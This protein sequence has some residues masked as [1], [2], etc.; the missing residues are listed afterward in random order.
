MEGSW[1]GFASPRLRRTAAFSLLLVCALATT[2]E[3]AKLRISN[4]YSAL[5]RYRPGREHTDYIVLHTT[6]GNDAPSLARVRQGGLAHYIVMRDGRVHRVIKRQLVARHAGRSMW[7]GTEN[8]D[9]HSIGIE[10]VG[11]HNRPLRDQQITALAELIRQLQST[12]GISD[13]HVLTHSMV[14]YGKPNRWH[15]HPHRGRKRCGMQF[16]QPELRARLGLESRPL[17]DPDVVA[18]RLVEADPYLA[19]VLYAPEEQSEAV[20][21][22]EFT[23]P[24]NNVISGTRT[25][26]FIARDLYDAPSTVYVLPSGKRVR[27][28]EITDWSHMPAGTQVLLDQ[29]QPA[30]LSPAPA[31]LTLGPN[32]AASLVAGEAYDQGT[33]VYV[34]PDGRILRGDTMSEHDFRR[35]P[36]GTRVFLGFEYAGKVTA[37]HTAYD[38]CGPR[39]REETTLYLLPG[40]R[41]KA[42]TEIREARI[43]GGTHVLVRS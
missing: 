14:A 10:V 31:F 23:G 11:Y 26:W 19:T 34:R 13:D 42:G 18:G 35:L 5:N 7:D 4:R 36:A 29:A 15:R 17:R 20:A 43:P 37:R 32:E 1:P 30:A 39:Y 16:A 25:A 8:L 6:E 38:L 22:A 27:G 28:N 21:A 24:D 33:T 41:V 9:Q 3:A 40:G 12:Y 2:A